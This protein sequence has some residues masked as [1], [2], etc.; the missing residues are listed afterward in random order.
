MVMSPVL[1]KTITEEEFLRLPDDGRK[2][3]LVEGKPVELPT[4]F[5][6]DVISSLLLARLLPIA[7]PLGYVTTG[8]SGCRMRSGNIRVPDVS[9]TRRERI[10]EVR[11]QPG[12]G[13]AAPDLC[14]EIISSTEEA[15]DIARKV[16]EYFASGAVLVW[17]LYPEE[18]FIEVFTSP[19]VSIRRTGT[20]ELDGG[21]LL[22][23]FRCPVAS[24]FETGL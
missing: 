10:N 7:L 9:F 18:Q 6:H 12:F 14:V 24:L 19:T 4:F 3:E 22:S 11:P 15:D 16:E 13:A 1:P 5:D 8:Q 20:D 2:W 17:H 23:G 21:D